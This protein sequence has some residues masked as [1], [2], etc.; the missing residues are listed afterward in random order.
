MLATKTIKGRIEKPTKFKFKCL[1]HEYDGFQQWMIFGID[2]GIYSSYKTAK[3]YRIKNIKYKE[4]PLELW[5]QL[6]KLKKQNTKTVNYWLLFRTKLK[7][8][9]IWLPI[10][11]YQEIPDDC[12]LKNSYL[13]YNH[14]KAWYDIRLIFS[15]EITHNGHSN[16]LAIDLGEK[17]IATVVCGNRNKHSKPLFFGKEIRGIRRHYSWLRKRLGNKKLLKIIK[18]IGQHEKNKIELLLHNISKK[19]INF[20]N[21]NKVGIIILGNLKNIR[22]TAKNKGKRLKRILSNFVYYKFTQILTYKAE[23]QGIKVI[24]V[25][26]SYSSKEC[27]YCGE[28]GKRNYQGLFKCSNCG[29]QINAD[30]NGVK[31]I[32]KRGIDYM[33][34]SGAVASAHNPPTEAGSII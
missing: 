27:S 6:T 2:L 5:S 34:I 28:F 13:V 33:F 3:D 21:Q 1:N 11:L 30:Y 19:I 15:K 12:K 17:R 9:G 26:E 23:W 29:C 14:Q 10:K 18:K 8:G 4:Y 31:N 25:D 24:K 22:E 32:L 16:L 7:R 20:S